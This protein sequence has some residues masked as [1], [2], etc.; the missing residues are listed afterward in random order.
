[1]QTRL[2]HPLLAA[3]ASVFALGP[4]TAQLPCHERGQGDLLPPGHPVAGALPQMVDLTVPEFLWAFHRDSLQPERKAVPLPAAT[5]AKVHAAL[6]AAMGDPDPDLRWQSLWALARLA[7][8]DA[9]IAAVLHERLLDGGWL[10]GKDVTAE[11]ALVAAGLS[12]HGSGKVLAALAAVATDQAAPERLRA[13]AFYGLGLAANNATTDTAQFRVLAAVERALLAGAGAPAEVRIAALHA[14]AL[15]RLELAPKL[16]GPALQLL[17]Q[18]WREPPKPVFLDF[19]AHVPIAVANLIHPDD[20]AAA[21][22]RE[23][24]AEVLRNP[25]VGLSVQRSCVIALGAICR[26]WQDASSPDARYG[27][28]LH[29]LAGSARDNQVRNFAWFA[30]GRM[31]GQSSR[32]HLRAGLGQ[33][34]DVKAWAAVGLAVTTA[35][36][37]SA[38]AELVAAVEKELQKTRHPT[39][40]QD[41]AAALR[42]VQRAEPLLPIDDFRERYGVPMPLTGDADERC[43]ALLAQLADPKQPAAARQLVAMALGHLADPSPRHWSASL[44]RAIDYRS[45]SPTLLARP[46]GVL[47]LP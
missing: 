8:H 10:R 2:P 16:P 14:L 33:R 1:M 23:R 17:E 30:L 7:R 28:L 38:D 4:A 47:R 41:L 44:A 34:F 3:M 27:E 31:G 6:L 43:L 25:P 11:V 32:E 5:L 46:N 24:F 36:S 42:V 9:A 13:F 19:P 45:A 22:W 12:A 15:V 29:T 21:A 18:A 26:P 40:R 39:V 37:T 20:P 35:T